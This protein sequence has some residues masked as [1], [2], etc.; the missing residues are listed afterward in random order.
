MH[1]S[2]SKYANS[3]RNIGNNSVD[4]NAG[5]LTGT[6][7]W[8]KAGTSTEAGSSA[9]AGWNR[10]SLKMAKNYGNTVC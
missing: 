9:T 4:S 10:H 6:G 7:T 3:S 1:A 2:I 5:M 8:A